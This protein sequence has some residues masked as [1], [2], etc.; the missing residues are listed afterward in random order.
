MW[1][2]SKRLNCTRENGLAVPGYSALLAH[3]RPQDSDS[4][5]GSSSSFSSPRFWFLRQTVTRRQSRASIYIPV[6]H[7]GRMQQGLAQ[8]STTRQ[9]QAKPPLLRHT[10]TSKT[11]HERLM[12]SEAALTTVVDSTSAA[13]RGVTNLWKLRRS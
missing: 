4:G 10:T 12:D 6:P 2:T 1:Y 9:A 7:G 3:G 5:S 8:S 13:L 11:R